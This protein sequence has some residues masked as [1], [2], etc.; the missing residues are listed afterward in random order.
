VFPSS[1]GYNSYH[2]QDEG[3]IGGL[4][5]P[6]KSTKLLLYLSNTMDGIAIILSFLINVHFALFVAIYIIA[7]RLYSNRNIRFKK[8]PFIG[9]LVVFR[10]LGCFVQIFSPCR[11]LIYF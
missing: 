6:P 2:D 8:Y 4:A 9:V 1:N 3:P 7:S 10:A 5:A 11:Q